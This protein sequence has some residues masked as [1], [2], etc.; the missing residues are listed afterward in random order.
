MNRI[1]NLREARDMRQIDLACKLNV[2]QGTLSNWERNVHDP[3][4]DALILL[5]NIF[6]TSIDDILGVDAQ[7]KKEPTPREE[8]LL[9][10][11]RI[12]D[13]KLDKFSSFLQSAIETLLE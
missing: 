11:D 7:I 12:P 1:K 4:S 3:D 13:D 6:N 2:S 8:L 9:L 5:A 10:I